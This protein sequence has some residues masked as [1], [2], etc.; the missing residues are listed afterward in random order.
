MM[1]FYGLPVG[2]N[3]RMDF[4]GARLL[5]LEDEKNKHLVKWFEVCR[6]KDLGGLGIQNLALVNKALLCKWRWKIFNAEGMWQD[7]IHNKYQRGKCLSG[8][9]AK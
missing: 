9:K 1:S 2:V 6:P 3:K 4:F 5:W 7:I 8:I